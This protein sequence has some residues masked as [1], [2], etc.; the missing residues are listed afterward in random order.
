MFRIII[1]KP[2][3][4]QVIKDIS[5]D[6][7]TLGEVETIALFECRKHFGSRFIML[8]YLTNMVYTVFDGLN[9]VGTVHIDAI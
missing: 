4:G 1:T 6:A 5:V 2:D 3:V 8:H 9:E 7:E